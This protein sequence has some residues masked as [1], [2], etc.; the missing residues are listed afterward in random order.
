MAVFYMDVRNHGTGLTHR[1]FLKQEKVPRE[2][3]LRKLESLFRL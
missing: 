3:R 2:H 1:K